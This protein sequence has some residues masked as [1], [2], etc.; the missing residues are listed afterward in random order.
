VVGVDGSETSIEALRFAL[1]EARLRSARV[2]AVC[3]WHVPPAAYGDGTAP[4]VEEIAGY[5]RAAEQAVHDA[6]ASAGAAEAGVPVETRV[7]HEWPGQALVTEAEH[8][9]LLVVGSRGLGG[10]RSLVL[11]S[12]SQECCHSASCPVVV[13]PAH[14]R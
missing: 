10:I 11:S 1:D 6:L 14:R 13:I 9:E 7:V 8:A 12:V 5:E 2:R 3:A 4:T